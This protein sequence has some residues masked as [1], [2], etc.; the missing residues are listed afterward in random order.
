MSV[1]FTAATQPHTC[2]EAVAP[3]RHCHFFSVSTLPHSYP[4]L[5][6]DFGF[7]WLFW[8]IVHT[9]ICWIG[10][11]KPF[12]FLPALMPS[13]FPPHAQWE[14]RASLGVILLEESSPQLPQ[15]PALQSP[16]GDRHTRPKCTEPIS[17]G[18]S[19]HL[20]EPAL[21]AFCSS[22]PA[23]SSSSALL[24][25]AGTPVA[26]ALL[27][28][29]GAVICIR[30]GKPTLDTVCT[31]CEDINHFSA[32]FSL[33]LFSPCTLRVSEQVLIHFKVYRSEN[34]EGSSK[35]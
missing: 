2:R 5:L 23:S 34:K 1:R 32:R 18:F 9:I 26:L 33:S 22:S 20:K 12:V 30:I 24:C 14:G 16:T 35:A 13:G 7:N 15:E 25:G 19:L 29:I 28:F 8:L 11:R 21:I 17:P 10:S 27:A 4:D 31:W 6:E 3:F